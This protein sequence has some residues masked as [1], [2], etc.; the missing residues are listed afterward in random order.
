MISSLNYILAAM[1][2]DGDIYIFVTDF[3]KSGGS[4]LDL[5]C[6]AVCFNS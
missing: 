3:D 5:F 2:H 6:F 1:V 4:G